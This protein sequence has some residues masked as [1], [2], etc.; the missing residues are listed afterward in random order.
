M[1]PMASERARGFYWA[2]IREGEE[3]EIAKWTGRHWIIAG[4]HGH[5]SDSNWRAI[6]ERI[7]DHE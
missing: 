7:P 1:I 3:W 5:Y 4:M 6:G 2:Q